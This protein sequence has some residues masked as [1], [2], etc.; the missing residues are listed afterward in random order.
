[1]AEEL[2]PKCAVMPAV[3]KLVRHLKAH[4]IP[5]AVCSG[6]SKYEFELKTRNHKELFDL[7][8]LKVDK[9]C[10]RLYMFCQA[11]VFKT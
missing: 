6:S 7:I 9:L 11:E 8:S 2:L 3:M 4:S 5:T 1:M 10:G